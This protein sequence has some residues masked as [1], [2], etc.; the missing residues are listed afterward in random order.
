M[1]GCGRKT[2]PNGQRR[3][4][5]KYEKKITAEL[6]QQGEGEEKRESR[7]EAMVRQGKA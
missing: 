3:T 1:G 5:K 6:D 7:V 4:L 2:Q